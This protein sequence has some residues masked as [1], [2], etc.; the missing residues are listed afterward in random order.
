VISLSQVRA[1]L[2]GE[3]GTGAA[4]GTLTAK[5]EADLKRYI[6]QVADIVRDE[7]HREIAWRVSEITT[8]TTGTADLL[9]IGHGLQGGERVLVAGSN[10]TPSVDGEYVANVIDEDTV[11]VTVPAD[12]TAPGTD[13]A[14]HVQRVKKFRS[15]SS[16]LLWVPQVATPFYAITELSVCSGDEWLL[17]STNDYELGGDL[18]SRKSVSLDWLGNETALDDGNGNTYFKGVGWPMEYG[19]PDGQY[20]LRKLSGHENIRM[21]Y[22]AGLRVVPGRLKA[23]VESLVL[24]LYEGAGGPK[25]I[26]SVSEEGV[27]S[28]R[29]RG[30]ERRQHIISPDHAIYAWKA[31]V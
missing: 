27:S 9:V 23:A 31:R 13:A 10:S 25:D 3:S 15:D 2:E 17:V 5:D 12:V 6:G 26:A 30:E 11:R 8:T 24:E 16:S 19:Y 29:M 4:I 1:E 22:W 18:R 20:G 28:T 7:T 14:F 21:T